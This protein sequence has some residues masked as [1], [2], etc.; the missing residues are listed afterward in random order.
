MGAKI[1]RFVAGQPVGRSGGW[2]VAPAH[3]RRVAAATTTA[4]AV[5]KTKRTHLRAL[6]GSLLRVLAARHVFER[7]GGDW[8]LV[9]HTLFEVL[10]K[11]RALV[12]VHTCAHKQDQHHRQESSIDKQQRS[13]RPGTAL[14]EHT[15]STSLLPERLNRNTPSKL[16]TDLPTYRG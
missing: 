4:A 8:Q 12:C 2:L 10:C 9:H 15:S 1:N 14:I 6:R 3:R 7:G 13:K 16:V 5:V 11:R